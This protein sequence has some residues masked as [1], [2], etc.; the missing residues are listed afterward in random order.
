MNISL[1]PHSEIRSNFLQLNLS[2]KN[3]LK[4]VFIPNELLIKQKVIKMNLS[5]L[6][7]L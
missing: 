3:V 5:L 2:I 4:S 7:N 6:C 1:L